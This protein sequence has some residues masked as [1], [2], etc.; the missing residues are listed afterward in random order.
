MRMQA[1]KKRI[2]IKGFFIYKGFKD[3]TKRCGGKDDVKNVA[4]KKLQEKE[5]L[6]FRENMK[7]KHNQESKKKK[8]KK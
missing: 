4:R 3:P 7:K 1:L 8:K 5:D 2:A 6:E